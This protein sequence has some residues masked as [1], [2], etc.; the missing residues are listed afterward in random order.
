MRDNPVASKRD[1]LPSKYLL[2]SVPGAYPLRRGIET[3]AFLLRR[4]P[5][6]L[7]PQWMTG[8]DEL[9]LAV[10]DRRIGGLLIVT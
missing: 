2:P 4:E 5:S 6:K 9:F 8:R 7:G 1:A 3:V 10:Q